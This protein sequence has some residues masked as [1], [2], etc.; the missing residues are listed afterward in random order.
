VIVSTD[1]P[2][3]TS[4]PRDQPIAVVVTESLPSLTVPSV[5]GLLQAT[6]TKALSDSQLT[7]SVRSQTV[8]YDD[9]RAGRV[10]AQSI[11]AGTAVNSGTKLQLTVA[12]AAAPPTTTTT[13][14]VGATTTTTG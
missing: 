8:P 2:A 9:A 11:P 5:T 6:A 12:A 10:I 1:P 14:V 4:V 7:V 13:T 3:G